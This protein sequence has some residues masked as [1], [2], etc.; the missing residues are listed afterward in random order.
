LDACTFR[1]DRGRRVRAARRDPEK[2]TV[3]R[4]A[5]E[6]EPILHAERARSRGAGGIE[7]QNGVGAIGVTDELEWRLGG[8][9]AGAM[10]AREPEVGLDV[11]CEH[12]AAR[13]DL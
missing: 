1:K 12:S 13:F 10:V 11:R 5:I 8:E 6:E 9:R 3:E 4:I 7:V 2:A